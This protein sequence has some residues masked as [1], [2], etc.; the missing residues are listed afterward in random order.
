MLVKVS[1]I[2]HAYPTAI[3]ELKNTQNLQFYLEQRELTFQQ[4]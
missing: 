4:C 2:L 1:W 3:L